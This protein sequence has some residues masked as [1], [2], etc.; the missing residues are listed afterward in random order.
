MLQVG[1]GPDLGEEPRGA[2]HRGELGAQ[3]L[4]GDRRLELEV[5]G[6]VDGGHA[7]R[8]DFAL[9]PVAAGKSSRKTSRAIRHSG[10]RGWKS[11]RL[12]VSIPDP[13]RRWPVLACKNCIT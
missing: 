6:Q 11:A 5:L 2:D 12:Y 7:T 1:R 9:D 8:T 10:T 4:E 13:Q 3:H